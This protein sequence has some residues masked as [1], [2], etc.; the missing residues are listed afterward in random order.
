MQRLRPVRPRLAL[1]D[2]RERLDR[3][4]RMTGAKQRL[5]ADAEQLGPPRVG[6]RNERGRVAGVL[7]GVLPPLLA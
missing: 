1:D 7:G 6:R 3:F 5:A 2:E 4:A